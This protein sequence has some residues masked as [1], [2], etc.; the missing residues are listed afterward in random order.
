MRNNTGQKFNFAT[1][2]RTPLDRPQT[3]IAQGF[4]VDLDQAGGD[5]SLFSVGAKDHSKFG[6]YV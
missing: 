3:R 4:V 5:F 6:T 2:C 1:V